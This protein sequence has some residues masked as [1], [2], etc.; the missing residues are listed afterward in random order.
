[1][2]NSEAKTLGPPGD[3]AKGD[4]P[5]HGTKP[6]R[7]PEQKVGGYVLLAKLGAGGIGE[8]WK[9][10]DTRLNRVVALKFIS[11]ERPGSSPIRDLLHEARAASAL[12]HPNIVTIFEV[13]ETEG[14]AFLAME[15]V[16]GETLRARLKRPPV[17]VEEA[18]DIAQQIVAGLA[19]A[20]RNGIV[21][22]D[23]KPE[24]IMLRVDGLV[25]LMDFGLAKV[26]PWADAS[27]AGNTPA[28]A[29]TES[30]AIV[31][32]LT[33]MSPEQARGRPVTAASDV[34][35]FGIIFY[36]LLTGEHPFQAETAMDTLTAILSKEPASISAKSPSTPA[37]L[38][39]ITARTL[40]KESNRRYPTGMDLAAELKAAISAQVTPAHAPEGETQV[41]HKPRWMRAIGVA[42]IATI[43]SLAAWRLRSSPNG[44]SAATPVRAVAV[45]SFRAAPEDQG[46][47]TLAQDLPEELGTAISKTGMQ[48]ASHQSVLDLGGSPKPRDVGSQLGVDAVMNGSVRTFGGRFKVYVELDNARTGFMVWSETFTFEG[49]DALNGEEKTAA[50]IAQ[51]MRQALAAQK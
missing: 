45:M 39:A 13:G 8:V 28:S 41:R 44:A 40:E 19:A 38:S 23:L 32:T 35:S 31:G 14:S 24:N 36:E 11:A 17:P 12:N 4:E 22:R 2:E 20:H 51:E 6:H 47:A 27:T 10:R 30:G 16:E 34:F 25:K 18:L 37:A 15:F 46:A 5:P 26:V 21:H 9:A 42:L 7:A 33:Y 48:V 43:L 29:A 50:Q 3:R 49:P 1:V